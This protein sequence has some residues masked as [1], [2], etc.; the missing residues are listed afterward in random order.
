[1]SLTGMR[2]A[3]MKAGVGIADIMCGMYAAI[4]LAALAIVT[5]PVKANILT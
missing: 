2:G 4:V 5:K 1:M 3:P